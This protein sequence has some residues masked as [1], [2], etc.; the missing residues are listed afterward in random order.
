MWRRFRIGLLLLVLAFVIIDNW[1][2]QQRAADWQRTLHVAVYPINGDGE[3]STAAYIARLDRDDFDA[4]ENFIERESARYGVSNPLPIDIELAPVV[5]SV[6]PHIPVDGGMLS[7]MW[8]SLQLRY[9]SWRVDNYRGPTPEVRLF[10]SY[11]DPALTP[12]LAHS[13]GL[14]KGMIGVI[15]VFSSRKLAARNNVVIT[16]ELLH[17]LGASDH[18]DLATN[19]P[20][21][22]EGYADPQQRPLYPQRR[23]EIMGGRIPL[24]ESKAVIPPGLSR[25]VV[26][27]KTAREIHWLASSETPQAQ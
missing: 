13:A 22:P 16:H 14:R 17:T 3:A 4:V 6:P 27:E 23:A 1:L 15:N 5:D 18:Y 2:T 12:R 7:A 10:V 19:M 8:W 25:T 11:F 21:F 9:W 24:T 20:I 26:G